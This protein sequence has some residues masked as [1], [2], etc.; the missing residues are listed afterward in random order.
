MEIAVIGGGHGSYAAAADLSD[1]GHN[2]RLWRRDGAALADVRER[3]GI[4]LK[5]AK[6]ERVVPIA[7][8]TDD[9]SVALADAELVLLPLPA[10]AQADVAARMAP[11]LRDD[12]VVFLTPGTFGTMIFVNAL[13]EA[14]CTA[15]PIFAETPTLPWLARKHGHATVAVTARTTKLPTGFFPASKTER[16]MAVVGRAFPEAIAVRDILDVVLLNGGPLIHPPLILMNA[17]PI[18]HFDR[19]DIHKEGTQP[20]IRAVHDA[21]DAERVAVREALGYG[22]P[23]WRLSDHY[24]GDPAKSMYGAMAHDKLTDSGD[25]SE[26]LDLRT[27]RYM[28]EDVQLGLALMVSMGEMAGIAMPVAAGLLAIAGAAVG[29]D[30]RAS[31]RTLES[32]GLGDMGPESL[33]AL[34]STGQ[35][36]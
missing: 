36:A 5:D 4:C 10:T 6:G 32:L 33:K 23:H 30:F 8:V 21:L 16:G 28:R 26:K 27:H 35:A 25:W 20:L 29:D 17:G 22:E 18:E 13:R 3:G 31:G 12:Q 9:L 15:M 7:K 19:W 11:H 1:A 24:S 34:A 14:G 2:V